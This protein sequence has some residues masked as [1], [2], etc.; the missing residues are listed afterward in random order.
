MTPEEEKIL[1]Q[2]CLE[3][4]KTLARVTGEHKAL[5]TFVALYV[6]SGAKAGVDPGPTLEKLRATLNLGVPPGPGGRDSWEG[7]NEAIDFI[8]R[9]VKPRG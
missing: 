5:M 2:L 9:I 3:N 6:K 7:M 8:E 1:Q 4:S